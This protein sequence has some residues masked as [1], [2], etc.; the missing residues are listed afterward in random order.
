MAGRISGITIEIGGDTTK[1]QTAL[2]GVDGQLKQTQTALKDINKLLKLNPA[3]TELLTQKQKNLEKAIQQTKDRLKQLKDAQK[4]VKEGSAEWDALQREIIETEQQLKSLENELRTFGSVGAQQIAV[5]GKAM[6]EFG[7]KCQEAASKFAPI[8]AGAGAL[9]GAL[10]GLGVKSVRAADDLNTLSKQSGIS[11]DTLQKMQYAADL[12]DVPFENISGAVTKMKKSMAGSGKPFEE[13]GVSVTDAE[14][15]MRDAESVFF[16]TIQALSEIPN[17]VERDQAAYEIFGKSADELAG[18]IDDG[19][20]AF[21]KYGKEAEDLGLVLSGETLDALNETN[22]AIDKSKAQL[23]AAATELGAT[24]ATGLVPVVERLSGLVE[25]FIGWLQKLTPEQTN[26]I[27]TIALVVAAIAPLLSI[28]AKLGG[29]IGGI[30][31]LAPAIVS[32]FTFLLSPIGLIIAGIAALIAIGIAL[33]THWDQVKEWAIQT[34]ENIKLAVTTAVDNARA[35]IEEWITN[36]QEKMTQFGETI[37]MKIEELKS[38]IGEWIQTNLVQPALDKIAEF[39]NVG[40]MVVDNIKS[41]ISSAWSGLASWFN[42]IWSSLFSNRTVD[43]TVNAQEGGGYATGLD[44]VPYNGFPAILHRGEA[45]LTAG[46]AQHWRDGGTGGID[47]DRLA[48][49]IASRPI[50]I[51]GD[52]NRIFKLVQKTNNV[53]TRATNYN[54]LA[55]G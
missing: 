23:K 49:A 30:L 18:I 2:K 12:I 20:E 13:L 29:L 15:N 32:A 21:R 16:D 47:Y 14:G 55:M 39:V 4:G 31:R 8:S 11:T 19:G 46:E 37:R 52:T 38:Q 48:A 5:A 45:V 44:Y 9:A 53:R 25:R 54:A 36:T 22:D 42:G 28:I 26:T 34:W 24:I 50:V 27:I 40:R 41:G 3:N 6:Q 51:E 7:E 35:K 43:V 1:L 33:Y 10:V 17:E